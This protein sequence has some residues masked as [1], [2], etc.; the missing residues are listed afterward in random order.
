M[1][2]GV[3]TWRTSVGAAL[4]ALAVSSVGA[5]AQGSDGYKFLKAVKERDGSA[6]EKLL[7]TPGS[8]IINT[9]DITTGET[10][11]ILAT[12]AR[13]VT[14]VRFLLGKGANPNLADRKG[15]TPLIQA[16]MLGDIDIARALLGKKAVIDQANQQGETPLILAVH[17]RDAAMARVLVQAGANPHKTDN[18]TGMSARDYAVRD[19]RT[20]ALVHV[21]DEKPAVAAAPAKAVQG[22]K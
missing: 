22:P 21:L 9:R 19:D 7:Q 6:A 8:L 15:N 13:D 12:K 2:V 11:L 17:R 16:A 5:A 3:R 20:G 10:G 4:L 18:L 1:N 14:W